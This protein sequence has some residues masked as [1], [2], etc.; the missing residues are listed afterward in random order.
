MID[1]AAAPLLDCLIIG[2][3]PAGL[4]A[5]IYLGRFRR[6]FVVLDAGA[7][8]ADWIPIS[9][10]HPGFPE[11][12][13]GPA[14][15]ERLR[16]QA[17]RYGARIVR[18]EVDWLQRAADGSFV[19]TD[20]A[21]RQLR[22]RTVI[23][24]TGVIDV[25]PELPNLDEAVRRGLIR[26]C[27]ICDGFEVIDRSVAVI[28]FGATGF[29]ETMFLRTYT[30]D[31]TLLTLGCPIGLAADERQ[32]M[33]EAGIRVIETPVAEVIVEA[34]QIT[35]LVLQDGRDLVFGTLYSAL[36]TRSRS[37]LAKSLGAHMDGAERLVTDEHQETSIAGLYAAGDI[38]RGLN[39]I[40]VAMG[41][42]EI[43][44]AAVHNRLGSIGNRV[45]R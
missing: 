5:A 15:L 11:G 37:G 22:G 44:A 2:G 7:S 25:E 21:G 23:L 26:H 3:G 35:R 28:G 45:R 6:R 12:I 4:T 9:H 34:E 29:G 8:R 20:A 1:A 19:A 36:G 16:H 41:Q 38:V 33:R 14:L 27:P 31:L 18:T 10:N 32:H 17:R 42:A 39:Q 40:G 43:A 24:A 30:S 13:P